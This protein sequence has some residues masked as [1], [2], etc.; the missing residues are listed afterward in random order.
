MSFSEWKRKEHARAMFIECG[1][2]KNYRAPRIC[3]RMYAFAPF[4]TASQT[5]LAAIAPMQNHKRREP[6]LITLQ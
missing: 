6:M 1:V 3:S 5:A 2:Q 4:N